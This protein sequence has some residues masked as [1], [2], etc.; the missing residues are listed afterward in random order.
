[1]LLKNHTSE[2]L[3][4]AELLDTLVSLKNGHFTA[5]MS[6]QYV[7]QAGKI[8]NTVNEILDQ[9]VQFQADLLRVTEEIGVTGRLGGQMNLPAHAAGGWK[10]MIESVNRMGGHLTDDLRRI[11]QFA[12]AQLKGVTPTPLDSNVRGEVRE[13]CGFLSQWSRPANGS[14]DAV[15]QDQ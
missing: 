8:A 6:Y 5:R 10:E 3:D 9:L 4:L 7:G 13:L 14:P 1:M 12:E 15:S 11:S 2:T